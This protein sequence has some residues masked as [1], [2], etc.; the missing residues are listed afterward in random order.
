[1]TTII[2]VEK[3]S[4]V[5]FGCDSQTTGFG[6][7]AKE[8]PKFFKNGEVVF[9]IA[10]RARLAQEIKYATVPRVKGDVFTYVHKVLVPFIDKACERAALDKN[11]NEFIVSVRGKVFEIQADR[12]VSRRADGVYGIGSGSAWAVA[13]LTAAETINV[14]TVQKALEV[15]AYHDPYTSSP[16][17]V[18]EG[19]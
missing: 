19:L 3:P 11:E 8:G 2:A 16:F 7:Y 6:K 14:N 4:G 5:I 9:A 18:V 13:Y 15:A 17:Y 10:G 12:N 1:M